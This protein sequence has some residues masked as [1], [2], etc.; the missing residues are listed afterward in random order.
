MLT[1]EILA[2]LALLLALLGYA[3]VRTQLQSRNYAGVS[4]TGRGARILIVDDDPDFLLITERILESHGYDTV[5]VSNG[6]D[7]LKV[8][9]HTRGTKPALV[10]LDIMMDYVTDGLDARR[11]MQQ[12]PDLRDIPVVMVTSLTGV[13][14]QQ[15]LPSDEYAHAKGWLTKP[16]TAVDLLNT[17]GAALATSPTRVRAAVPVAS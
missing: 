11:M 16:V 8:L 13:K 6:T 7:A 15:V 2:V 10:L 9:Y 14:A 3:M 17:V 12:H 5:T 1:L 4:D